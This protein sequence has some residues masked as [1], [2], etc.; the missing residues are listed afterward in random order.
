M[1]K[2][3]QYYLLFAEFFLIFGG[4]PLL[5]L[6][7][8]ER[9]VRFTVLWVFAFYGLWRLCR[10]G[11]FSLKSEWNWPEVAKGISRVLR[12]FAPCAIVLV[13]MLFVLLPDRALS[14]PLERTRLWLLILL[15]YPLLSV[16]PQEILYRSLFHSRY[17]A[18]FSSRT[19]I[20]IVAG[21]VFG[22]AHIIFENWVAVFL[23]TIGGVLFSDTYL[24]HRSLALV[25]VEHSLYGCFIFTIGL[26]TYFYNGNVG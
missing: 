18:L 16:L 11:K 14:L 21:L 1:S 10:N 6:L 17:A 24:R 8:Q 26:G 13:G 15:L 5:L 7:E 2:Q 20:F 19:T 3:Q 22:W 12:R 25:W 9:S 4:L 23:C